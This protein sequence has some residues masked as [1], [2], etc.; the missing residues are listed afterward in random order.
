MFIFRTLSRSKLYNNRHHL[1]PNLN[2]NNTQF[3]KLNLNSLNPFSTASYHET[4]D[5]QD[6]SNLPG[7]LKSSEKIQSFYHESDSDFGI[8]HITDWAKE[9]RKQTQ[10]E[11][12]EIIDQVSKVLKFRYNSPDAAAEA[13][14]DKC[15]GISV[16]DD[17]VSKLLNRF[18]NDYVRAFGIFKWMKMRSG[19]DVSIST[20]LYNQMVDI[21]G[22][23]KAFDEMWEL[24]NEMNELGKGYVTLTTM[25]KVIRRFAKAG[26]FNEAIEAFTCIERYGLNR[27]VEAMNILLVPLVRGASIETATSVFTK[28]KNEIKPTLETYNILIQ[29]YCKA[30]K[31]DRGY[32]VLK[33]MDERGISPDTATYNNFVEYYSK[34][35]DFEKVEEI[36]NEMRDKRCSPSVATYTI[37]AQALTKS[38]YPKQAS[39]VYQKMKTDGCKPDA[40]FYNILIS[41]FSKSGGLN[42]G[43][44]LYKEMVTKGIELNLT[45]YN[46]MIKLYCLN[47]REED[48]VRLLLKMKATSVKPDVMTFVSFRNK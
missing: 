39:E 29:G 48:A 16:S 37:Y 1:V 34:G 21:L 41:Q 2:Y 12:L 10:N 17:L 43:L 45:R 27:D 47:A 15:S 19:R 13:L 28:F 22:K 35:K 26:E 30:R 6:H 24:V 11:E 9:C 7:W 32:K 46:S 40:T 42:D 23:C 36:L 38:K 14:I 44:A 18:G 33:E 4:N 25:T 3:I 20:N 5:Y 31:I 8:P